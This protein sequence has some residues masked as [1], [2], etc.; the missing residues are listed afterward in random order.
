MHFA[1]KSLIAASAFAAT[2][3]LVASLGKN[4]SEDNR[5]LCAGKDS[6]EKVVLLLPEKKKYDDSI[7]LAVPIECRFIS[8]G[9]LPSGLHWLNYRTG[10]PAPDGSGDDADLIRLDLRAGPYMKDPEVFRQWQAFDEIGRTR[11][12]LSYRPQIVPTRPEDHWRVGYFKPGVS[13]E[14]FHIR[15]SPE[16]P[17]FSVAPQ[18]WCRMEIS[19][20]STEIGDRMWSAQVG[21]LFRVERMD[22]WPEIEKRLRNLFSEAKPQ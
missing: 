7:Q 6:R 21:A 10:L 12:G 5:P 15:C 2:T 17:G 14:D 20:N 8:N 18:K 9:A 1:T 16:T 22:D 3:A 13:G 4:A 11:F 19:L